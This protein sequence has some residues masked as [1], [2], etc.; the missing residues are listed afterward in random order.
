MRLSI[1]RLLCVPVGID[2]SSRYGC[3]SALSKS[4]LSAFLRSRSSFSRS[5]SFRSSR[6]PFLPATEVSAE[7]GSG[8]A[9]LGSVKA[10]LRSEIESES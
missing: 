6:K 4:V 8:A 1:A 5:V 3:K 7:T 10:V 9:A 2:P